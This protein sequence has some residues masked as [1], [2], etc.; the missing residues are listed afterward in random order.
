MIRKWIFPAALCIVAVFLGLSAK[1]FKNSQEAM[2]A[3]VD[4]Q[5]TA[6]SFEE[7]V[8]VRK[9]HV[10]P[11]Q[12]VQKGE[13]LLEVENPRLQLKIEK[14]RSEL[15]QLKLQL[16]SGKAD[17]EALI[18]LA[19]LEHQSKLQNLEYDLAEINHQILEAE[20][21]QRELRALGVQ[22][23][24]LKDSLLLIKK[25]E[26]ELRQKNLVATLELTMNR[27]KAQQTTKQQLL[28][29][30]ITIVAQE[31]ASANASKQDLVRRADF[32]GTIGT[33]NV[34]LGELTAP[35]KTLLSIY[36]ARPRLIKAFINERISYDVTVGQAVRI[37]SENRNYETQGR[38]IEIGSRITSFPQKIEPWPQTRSYGQEIFVQID[39]E[40]E[41][42][43]GEKVFVE[44]ISQP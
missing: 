34:Q 35:F 21:S 2:A 11:G 32:E 8:I 17:T 12:D 19:R 1:I 28:E 10:V 25:E 30:Q 9:I 7:P 6:V 3:V 13:L 41:F 27:L 16:A 15:T 22:M 40:S 5:V 26:T 14:L 37:L 43:H 42:L 38:I 20:T 31:L 33:L 36:E 39:T 44:P 18:A 23:T 29:E 24:P 4:A